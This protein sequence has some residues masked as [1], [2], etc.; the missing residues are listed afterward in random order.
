MLSL[1]TL[2]LAL[3]TAAPA[4]ARPVLPDD[5]RL[6]AVRPRLEQLIDRLGGAGLPADMIVAKVREG[7]AKGADPARIE[8]AAIR[9]A[10][11]LE[12]A[13]RYVAARRPGAVAAPLV[14]AVAEAR[15]AGVALTAIDPLVSPERAEPPARRAVEVVTDLSLRGYPPER[16]AAVVKDV[17]ARDLGALDRLSATLE[18][19]RRE[20]ALSRAEAVDALARGLASSDTL[21]TA[22]TRTAEDERRQ[23]HGGGAARTAEGQEGAPGKSGLAPGHLPKMKP[24]T[25]GPKKNR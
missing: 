1:A 16:A 24:P 11:S 20:Y 15:L 7:L 18:I 13:Q 4:A 25:A 10:D 3:V 22:Y 23:G 6:A 8:A 2:V 5:A 12:A 17:L 21:Q 19:L 14:R 9:L